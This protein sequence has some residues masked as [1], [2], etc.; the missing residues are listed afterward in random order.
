MARAGVLSF[1]RDAHLCQGEEGLVSKLSVEQWSTATESC[2]VHIK[3][4]DSYQKAFEEGA[5][6]Q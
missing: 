2:Q 3:G 1:L 6:L 5:R 4:V